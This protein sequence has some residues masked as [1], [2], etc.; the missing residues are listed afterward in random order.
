V[1]FDFDPLSVAWDRGS[2]VRVTM[3]WTAGVRFPDRD[4][5][6]FSIPHRPDRVWGLSNGYRGISPWV[7]RSKHEADQL[8]PSSAEVKNGGDIPPL[9]ILLYGLM[10]I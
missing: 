4:E 10:L 6:F 8:L 3:V 7:K 2:S 1:N 5:G 9:P